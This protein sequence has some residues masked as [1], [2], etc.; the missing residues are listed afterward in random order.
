MRSSWV[1]VRSSGA[2]SARPV[3]SITTRSNW[4]RPARAKAPVRIAQGLRQVAAQATADAAA[5]QFDHGLFCRVAHQQMVERRV[6][7]LVDD[8][9]RIG[10][11]RAA[12]AG[13]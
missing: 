1:S 5:G 11:V 10:H 4:R 2:G 6:A 8:D 12:P 9:Q 3:V 13:D 7:V